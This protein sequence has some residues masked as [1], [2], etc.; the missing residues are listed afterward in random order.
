[1]KT[2]LRTGAMFVMLASS[3]FASKWTKTGGAA[4][5]PAPKGDYTGS[6]SRVV[7]GNQI[8]WKITTANGVLEIDNSERDL[9]DEE[10]EALRVAEAQND[11][12]NTVKIGDKGKVDSV[13]TG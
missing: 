2:L 4:V 11:K 3:A 5:D 12:N 10:K 1:M 6:V 8:I 13:S 9:T 7:D